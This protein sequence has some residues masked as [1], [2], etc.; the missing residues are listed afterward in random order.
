[1]DFSLLRKENS[2]D[3]KPYLK[4]VRTELEA[5]GFECAVETRVKQNHS[6]IESA[7][8]KGNTVTNLMTIKVHQE[9]VG[10]FHRNQKIKIKFEVDTDPPPKAGYNVKN[11][12]VPIPF[13]VKVFTRPDLFAGKMHAV[14]CRQ[15]KS[16]VKGRDFYDLIWF[17]GQKIPCHLDHLKERMIQTNHWKREASLNRGALIE[18]LNQK[19][20]EIDFKMLK[21]D[22]RPF[23]RDHHELDLW[24][25][26]FFCDIILQLEVC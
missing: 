5:F 16:R 19:F 8:I 15:W 10:K 4:A 12:L 21:N 26:E 23:I 11:I 6:N 18:R 3:L 2:F 24:S 20:G 22:V 14:L 17:L 9:I 1:M 7:F 13:Q 25:Q